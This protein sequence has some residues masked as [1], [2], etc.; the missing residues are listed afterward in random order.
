MNQIRQPD[1]HTKHPLQGNQRY[2]N[3][4]YLSKMIAEKALQTKNKPFVLL[5]GITS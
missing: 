1:F 3:G 4:A 2:L 5:Q